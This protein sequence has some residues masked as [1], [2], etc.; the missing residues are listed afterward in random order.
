[1]NRINISE[2]TSRSFFFV[3]FLFFASTAITQDNNKKITIQERNISIK[4][5]FT[6]IEQQTGYSIA[7]EQSKLDLKKKISLSLKDAD[8]NKAL[9]QIL[10]DSKHSYKIKGYHIIISPLIGEEKK[11][12]K[13][14]PTQTIKGQIIDEVSELPISYASVGILGNASIGTI[15]DSLGN[16]ILKDVPIGR[17]DIQASYMGYEPRILREILVGSAK[18]VYV[19]IPL[20]EN[21]HQLD[22]VIVRP[23][24]NKDQPLN[25]LVITGGRMVSMEEASRFANGFDDPARLVSAFAGVAGNVGN[26]AIAIRGNSPQFTQWRLEGVEI[27]NPTHFADVSGLGGGFLSAL[28][29]QVMGNFDFYNGAFSAEYN[30]AMSGVFD[31][32]MRNGNNQ[33]HEYTFQIGVLGIDLASE[34]PIS[35][36]HKSSYIFNYRFSTTS[37]ATGNDVNMKYQDLSFKL[38]FPT[39]KLGT[40]SIWGLGLFDRNKIKEE[41]L[42]KWEFQADRQ[43]GEN[44]FEKVAGGLTHKYMFNSNTYLRSSLAATYSHDRTYANQLTLDKTSVIPVGDIQNSKWDIVFNT[45]L[46]K[47]FSS[48]HVNRTGVS[49]TG[50]RYDLDYKVSPDFGLDKPMERIAKGDGNSSVL[51]AFNTS[52]IDL[53]SN[54]VASIGL[55]SQYFALNR[56][57]TLEPRTSL[58]WKFKP[59]QSL[60][61]AYGLHSRR[62]RLDYYFVEQEVDGKIESNKYL[63]FSKAHHFGLSYDWNITPI[64]HLKIEPYYQYLYDIPVER[65]TS[66][67]VINQKGYYLD[68]ILEN[69]GVGKNYGID[70][71]FEQYI[72]KGFYY[73]LTG[74][75]FKSK[76]RGGDNIWR[77]TRYD[78]G[79][80]V[81]LV[82]GKEW[83]VG[84]QKQ[85]ILGINTRLFFQG[86]DRYIPIDEEKSSQTHDIEF[87]ETRAFSKKFNPAINGDISI[88]YKINRKKISHEF[89]LKI[90]NIGGYTGMHYYKYN[91]STMEIKK[92][93]GIGVMPNISYKIY[94]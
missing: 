9:S 1:M 87:D 91:E 62:E 71:T 20:K 56:N 75:L 85:N 68:R 73:M 52:V 70:I 54:L 83:M 63:N 49:V 22:E 6:K 7:Y 43:S 53:S 77:D 25:P 90:L 29:T 50:L 57:W 82:A 64:H 67:S 30:N 93:K 46:N 66:F 81:N 24:I 33:N 59:Q 32:Y 65:G 69:K 38:N 47:K 74:S 14:K 41:D 28:S 72:N 44:N 88:N 5:A 23:N 27:P 11:E 48:R 42:D 16:F 18:E 19:K 40:F 21:T 8:I 34:G 31:T 94:F 39:K 36:K 4:E 55:T 13:K 79:F 86:G 2:L 60:A 17:Y 58:K 26:N 61:V 37:L 3:L 12:D 78:R 76:Y 80:A 89:S 10:K 15:T 51:S 45:Y 92:E 35:K 84:K